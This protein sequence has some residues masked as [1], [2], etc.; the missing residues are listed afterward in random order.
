MQDNAYDCGMFMLMTMDFLAFHPE[1]VPRI[2]TKHMPYYRASV[3]KSLQQQSIEDSHYH[4]LEKK[5]PAQ[6]MQT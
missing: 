3:R 2:H 1:L 5:P 6:V 4:H